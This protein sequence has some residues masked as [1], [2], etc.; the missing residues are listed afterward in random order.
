MRGEGISPYVV[1]HGEIVRLRNPGKDARERH[2]ILRKRDT[3]ETEKGGGPTK[4]QRVLV[5]YTGREL[6]GC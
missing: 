5:S 6:D 3:L 1:R 2:I 4:P